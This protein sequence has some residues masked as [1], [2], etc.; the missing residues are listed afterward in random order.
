MILTPRYRELV[1][2]K[3]YANL[4]SEASRTYLSFLWWII[5]PILTMLVFYIVFGVLLQR[6]TEDFVPF[7]LIGL[8]IW[9]WF[10]NTIN[11]GKS[12][13]LEN[14][15]L[16]EQVHLPKVIFPTIII[17]MDLFKFFIVF[18]LIIIFLWLYGFGI[19]I[20]YLALPA[21]LLVQF[22]LISAFTYFVAAIVPFIPDLKFLIATL[23]QLV[24]FL[25]GIFF[26]STA[27]SE[28]NKFYFYLNPMA[29]L[30]EDYRNV[31]MYGKWPDW[32]SLGIIGLLSVMGIIFSV[33]LIKRF[34]YIYPR[35]TLQ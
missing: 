17:L 20:N 4:N 14:R 13:I 9:Q 34:D 24:F 18:L 33:R 1:L 7:L 3:T 25:T 12:S 6:G 8:T 23:I 11:H 16:M 26:P 35:V 27:I 19:N 31:L 30:I 10:A 32:N 28:E 29:N 22:L 5:D 15:R 2:F 21:L